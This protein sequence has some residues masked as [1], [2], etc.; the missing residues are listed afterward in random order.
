MKKFKDFGIKAETKAFSGKHMDIERLIGQ[1]I[2][3]SDYKIGPSKYPEKGNGL[4]LDLQIILDGAD[5]ITWT[6]GIALQQMI[7]A[8]PEE[9]FPFKTTIIRNNKRYEFS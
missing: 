4:R 9:D 1:E 7:K 8:V 3:I 6:G 5:R 2:I